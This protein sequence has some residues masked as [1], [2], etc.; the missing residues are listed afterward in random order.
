M[1]YIVGTSFRVTPNPKFISRDKRFQ[2][3]Q[4]YTLQYISK[5]EHSVTYIFS[6][7]GQKISIDFK[8][9]REGDAFISKYRNETIPN[10]EEV[11]AAPL[12]DGF[13]D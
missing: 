11:F 5:K 2:P 4:I 6:S 12:T 9:C 8:N 13:A 3:G 1:H 7:N 10:Y